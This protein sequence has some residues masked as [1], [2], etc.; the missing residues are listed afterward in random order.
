MGRAVVQ[1]LERATGLPGRYALPVV[2]GNLGLFVAVT[3]M[4]WDIG[5]HSDRG[6]DKPGLEGIL[7]T[8]HVMVVFGFWLIV[9]TVFLHGRMA[10]PRGPNERQFLNGR[11]SLAPGALY[12][13][14]CGGIALA[15]FPMDPVW[16]ALFGVDVTL[17]SPTHLFMVVG[18]S[19]STLGFWMLLREGMA[20]GSPTGR[21]IRGEQARQAGAVL[22]GLSTVQAEFDLGMPQAQL[23]YHPVMIAFA[24]GIGLVA[25][26]ALLG[27]GG[28]LKALALFFAV[29]L[30]LAVLVGTVLVFTS[31]RFAL[32]LGSAL[33]IEA[34]ALLAARARRPERFPLLAGLGIGTVGLATEWGWAELLAYHTWSG[35]LMPEALI[36]SL[37]AGTGGAYVGARIARAMAGGEAGAREGAP[38]GVLAPRISGRA[39]AVAAVAILVALAYPLPRSGGDGTRLAMTPVPAGDGRVNVQVTLD[40][41]DANKGSEWFYVLAWQGQS[42]HELIPLEK[43]GPGRW[44][45]EDPAPIGGT[46]KTLVRLAKGSHLMAT[47]VYLPAAPEQDRPAVAAQARSGPM[48]SEIYQLLREARGQAAW[49]ETIMYGVMAAMVVGWVMLAAW[50]LR[51]LEGLPSRQRGLR[52]RREPAPA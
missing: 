37:L 5:Y 30:W 39:L 8:P 45:T 9:T 29:R 4:F 14:F 52:P 40:P 11:L 27:P 48:V 19:V 50:T 24:A 31:P 34:A 22:L 16:H 7:N 1:R 42:R 18:G 10:G 47:P 38:R 51:L 20:L 33:A 23:L 25:A 2:V 35:S 3:G 13:L 26:R 36:L 28:A 12:I 32:Y 15:G 46:W 21:L 17:W 6:R 43:V 44:V 41:P 49:V